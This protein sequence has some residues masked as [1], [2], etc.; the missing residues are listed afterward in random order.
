MLRIYGKTKDMKRFKALDWKNGTFQSN[1]IY[2]SYFEDLQLEELK[3]EIENNKQQN[4]K[5]TLVIKNKNKVI[6]R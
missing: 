4:C 6:Y 5:V 1:L 3:K 2:A